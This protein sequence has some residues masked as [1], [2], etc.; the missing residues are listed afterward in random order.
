MLV[1]F[2]LF[3][4]SI[5]AE[6]A[7]SYQCGLLIAEGKIPFIDF[8]EVSSPALMYLNAI[9]A[10]FG[11]MVPFVHPIVVFHVFVVA[12]IAGS[13]YLSALI[14]F[15]QRFREQAHAP[16]F[17]IGF[18]FLNLIMIN[19][20]GQREHLFL[21]LYTPFFVCRWL[22]WTNQKCDEKLSLIAGIAGGV[23]A[24]LD[25][26]FLVALMA[27]ELF[28]LVS[29]LKLS[30]FRSREVVAALAVVAL[31][32][33]HFFLFP[34]DYAHL[35]FNWALPMV[36]CDYRVF[37]ERLYWVNKTPDLRNLIYFII[38]LIACS[39]G[40]RRW[41]SLI[42]PCI[43]FCLLGF[44]L[45][46]FEGKSMTY[47]AL[48]MIFGGGL[49]AFLSLSV[50]LHWIAKEKD[51]KSLFK[52]PVV[53]TMILLLALGFIGVKLYLANDAK[54]L[55]P[56]DLSTVGYW[57]WCYNTDLPIRSGLPTF[58]TILLRDTKVGDTALIL[59]D[60]VRPAYPLLLQ[61]NR[62]PGYLLTGYAM[63]MSRRL[64]EST[65]EKAF[66][67]RGQ[68]FN[69]FSRLIKDI[70]KKPNIILIEK[71]D[72]SLGKVLNE[73]QLMDTINKYYVP[74]LNLAEWPDSEYVPDYDFFGFRNGL[75]VYRLSTLP[76]VEVVLPPEPV[77][78]QVPEVPAKSVGPQVPDSV[79]PVAPSPSPRGS[80]VTSDDVTDPV[81]GL[82]IGAPI[83]PVAPPSPPGK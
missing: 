33:L 81:T 54:R 26:L 18:A 42:A 74:S 5:P 11:S 38:F 46:I 44:G 76:P 59:N 31:Y 57:G 21:L 58:S 68:Q 17:I 77:V 20:A 16:L 78:P 23:A 82:P 3:A 71:S 64:M 37:D 79:I 32:F 61:Y 15:R 2:I 29:K 19:E 7:L 50:V 45:L 10:M 80:N 70:E 24:C 60:R 27:M 53:T 56:L 12:L 51:L 43:G 67:Y 40:L 48:P 1:H 22:T 49:A 30:P 28:F 72:D 47:Q 13:C 75:Y 41:C 66:E 25:P 14:L 73:H 4:I 52:P 55:N 8:F 36:L 35:Y 69:M 34:I 6:A 65:P 9:P 83:P 63:R 62:K 39:L